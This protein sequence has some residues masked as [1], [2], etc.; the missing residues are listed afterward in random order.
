M[1]YE[2]SREVTHKIRPHR[3]IIQNIP[4]SEKDDEY[5]TINKF[6]ISGTIIVKLTIFRSASFGISMIIT[7]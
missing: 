6:C 1:L 2:N 4:L 7:A 3:K 5:S